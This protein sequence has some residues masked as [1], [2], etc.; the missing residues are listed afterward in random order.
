M[1]ERETRQLAAVL[2]VVR[3]AKDHPT[4]ED[5]FRRVQSELPGVSLGTV[6]RNL[7]KLVAQA[8]VRR[9]SLPNHVVRYDGMIEHHD[10]FVCEC[11]G[12]VADLISTEGVEFAALR[13]AGYDVRSHS[14]TVLGFCPPCGRRAAPKPAPPQAWRRPSHGV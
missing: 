1:K 7:H 12:Q 8:R 4:A 11:C 9:V 3:R 13:S 14:L 2:E 10:H 6:Y 5:I